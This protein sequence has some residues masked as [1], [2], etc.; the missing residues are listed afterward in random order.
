MGADRGF[1]ELAVDGQRLAE[2]ENFRAERLLAAAAD[3]DVAGAERPTE[4]R[5]EPGLDGKV[6]GGVEGDD[7]DRLVRRAVTGSLGAEHELRGDAPDAFEARQAAEH[8]VVEGEIGR[9]R[10]QQRG[11]DVGERAL[12][13]D[14]QIRTEPGEAHGHAAFD[15]AQEDDAGKGRAG[16]DR[17]RHEQERRAPGAPPEILQ[18]QPR[19]QEPHAR[20][21]GRLCRPPGCLQRE[22]GHRVKLRR[23]IPSAAPGLTA[24]TSACASCARAWWG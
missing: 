9:L 4:A 15:A 19:E 21:P 14:Q 10:G 17:D 5:V 12:R 11:G 13:N 23:Q 20:R 8:G 16:A 6:A 1:A 22:V 18:R 24:C 7:V 2:H 3:D